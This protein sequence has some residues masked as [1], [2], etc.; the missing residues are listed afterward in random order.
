M[1]FP[2]DTFMREWRSR[3]HKDAAVIT[4]A[5]LDF[6]RD[7]LEGRWPPPLP[8]SPAAQDPRW[9][10]E[11]RSLIG[12]REIVGPKHNSWIAAS[13]ARLGARWFNDD[14]TP[15]CGLFVAHCIDAAGLP[16]P[17]EF[18][19]ARAWAEWGKPCKPTVGA[20]AVFGRAGG[21]HV[22]FLV[23]HHRSDFFVLGGNQSNAVN[24]MRVAKDRLLPG[25]I[26]WPSSLGLPTPVLPLMSGGTVSVNEA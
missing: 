24:I 19:R 11:A 1:T 2:F 26:R 6:V 15:W 14:E 4:Q 3:R 23:G 16:Y 12:T 9:L 5:E 7:A 22:G 21:G 18:P 13:W 17:K 10:V 20:V 25:G 8:A